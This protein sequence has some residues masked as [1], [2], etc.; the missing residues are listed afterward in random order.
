MESIRVRTVIGSV[1]WLI[2]KTF[3]N[4]NRHGTL[5]VPESGGKLESQL[6]LSTNTNGRAGQDVL[7]R[8]P[9]VVVTE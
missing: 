9:E 1:M 3:R 2:R 5:L 4:T 7:F 8:A 6:L